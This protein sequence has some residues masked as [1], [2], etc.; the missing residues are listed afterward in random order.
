MKP[1]RA[2]LL[3]DSDLR[4]NRKRSFW[5]WSLLAVSLIVLLGL[6]LAER[7]FFADMPQLPQ[8]LQS[9]WSM[10]KQPS[11]VLLDK[12]GD[13]LAR[14]GPRYGK[15]V[16]VEKMPKHLVNAFLAMEDQR[17]YEHDGIDKKGILRAAMAN[18]RAGRTA[19]GGSTITQQLVKLLLLNPERTVKRKLQEMRLAR[20]LE[21]K[22]GKDE[23]LALY[24]NRI[25]LGN[26]AYGVDAAAERYFQ[27]SV[28][29]LTLS[30]ASILAALPKAPSRFAPHL[31][32]E[33][34]AN[35]AA[36]VLR[37]MLDAGYIDAT[38]YATATNAPATSLPV[39]DTPNHGY[40]FDLAVE[41]ANKISGGRIPD[42][43]IK[44]TIDPALQKTAETS[45][46]QILTKQGKALKASQGA[47]ISTSRNGAIRAM[48]GG[49]AYETSKFNRAYRAKRQPGSAFKAFVYAAALEAGLQA[50][51]VRRDKPIEIAGWSP[52]N[53]GGGYRGRVTLRD[54]FRRSIN[55]VAAQITDEIGADRVASLATRF[56]IS[57]PLQALPSI[58]LGAQEVNLWELTQA[59]SVFGNDGLMQESY[60]I[61]NISTSYGKQLYQRPKILPR[62]V[63]DETYARQMTSM[64]QEVVLAGTGKNAALA[65]RQVAG[66]TGTSQQWR[67]AWFIGFT[68]QYTT[69]VWVGNDDNS[70][71]KKVTGGG[72]PA[73]I[74]QAYM[75]SAHA[76]LPIQKLRSTPPQILSDTDEGLAAYYSEL[77]SIFSQL[78]T[79]AGSP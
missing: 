50:S 14:R 77:G 53:Y 9:L 1:F 12:N 51:S 2:D 11:Y 32:P 46:Q 21:T 74:W 49:V 44:T 66:K 34:A 76:D 68:A 37:A 20:V 63:M 52:G 29:D 79:G 25:Y 3:K 65:N 38:Q 67:D 19:Q 6:G 60:L 69:G 31:H 41:R 26:R 48:V 27:K 24:L 59:F 75:R 35:R 62:R 15:I 30:E 13:V 7:Y 40:I 78:E 64:M 28:A 54:A 36:L 71:M 72:L 10:G 45:L 56:G 39:T 22:L 8:N 18:W 17:F 5:L 4:K 47:L 43:V 42:L 57:G 33:Q 58:A 55:T 70:A 16:P 23:I 73:K 61:E